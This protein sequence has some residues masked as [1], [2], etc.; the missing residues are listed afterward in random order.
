MQNIEPALCAY[1]PI[2][3]SPCRRDTVS[4]MQ[5]TEDDLREFMEIW[6]AEFS[7]PLTPDDAK[8]YA[9]ALMELYMLL[10]SP[11]SEEAS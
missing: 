1:P 8:R 9:S 5:L 10:T 6:S 3:L 11:W 4:C 2:F 7:E